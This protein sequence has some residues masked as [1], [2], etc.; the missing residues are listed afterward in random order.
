MIWHFFCFAFVYP[1]LRCLRPCIVVQCFVLGILWIMYQIFGNIFLFEKFASYQSTGITVWL[2]PSYCRFH[3]VDSIYMSCGMAWNYV[4][5][6]DDQLVMFSFSMSYLGT[7]SWH[8]KLFGPQMY[9][10][11]ALTFLV[12]SRLS[13]SNVSDN[14]VWIFSASRHFVWTD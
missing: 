2:N 4:L 3:V 5:A 10:Q 6:F 14:P 9:G 13:P 8:I 11:S 1:M 12:L 7:K